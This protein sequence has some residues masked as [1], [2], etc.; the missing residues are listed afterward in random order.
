MTLAPV[1]PGDG[2]PLDNTQVRVRFYYLREL[3]AELR[4]EVPP[5]VPGDQGHYSPPTPRTANLPTEPL[6]GPGKRA[7]H[8]D[9]RKLHRLLLAGEGRPD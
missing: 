3:T 6:C 7:V 1:V 9:G 2:N 4:G 8:D 5:W